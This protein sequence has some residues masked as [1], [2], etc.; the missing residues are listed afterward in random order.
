MSGHFPGSLRK[1]RSCRCRRGSFNFFNF[2]TDSL[3]RRIRCEVGSASGADDIPSSGLLGNSDGI[4]DIHKMSREAYPP[5]LEQTC[6]AMGGL[7]FSDNGSP[8]FDLV[9]VFRQITMVGRKM[10]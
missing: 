6:F 7:L 10:G 1:R 9:L 3:V 4:F 8:G 2:V 5:V